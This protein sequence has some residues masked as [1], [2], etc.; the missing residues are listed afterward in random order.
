M[1]AHTYLT[2]AVL[3][4]CLCSP[5]QAASLSLGAGA[6]GVFNSEANLALQI[7]YN[8][9]PMP[10]WWGIEP[11][12]NLLLAE[13]STHYLSAGLQKSFVVTQDWGWGVSAEAGYY[14]TNDAEQD[15]GYDTI[16]KTRIFVDYGQFRLALSHLS[17]ADLGDRNPGSESMILSWKIPL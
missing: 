12:A 1:R 6:V 7:G 11:I 2:T 15:L 3:T 9:N 14:H 4:C 10:K 13:K 5:S 8:A 16:F 17:N